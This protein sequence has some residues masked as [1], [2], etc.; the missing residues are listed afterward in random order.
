MKGRRL[1]GSLNAIPSND[2]PVVK[3]LLRKMDVNP[4]DLVKAFAEPHRTPG[5]S[6]AQDEYEVR[7]LLRAQVDK[8]RERANATTQNP[9]T[10]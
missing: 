7:L 9:P 6:K 2:L 5:N 3:E 10:S 4:E 1:G 8:V